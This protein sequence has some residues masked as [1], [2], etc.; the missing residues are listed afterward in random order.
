M[1]RPSWSLYHP[2]LIAEPS[3]ERGQVDI[4]ELMLT[5]GTPQPPSPAGLSLGT[6]S[7]NP[8]LL[9]GQLLGA[10]GR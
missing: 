9:Q 8:L 10:G 5:S 3:A 2:H 6:L 1:V 4:F 7:H